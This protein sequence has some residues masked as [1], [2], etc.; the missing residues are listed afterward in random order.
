MDKILSVSISCYN[1]EEYLYE[2][3][4]PFTKLKNMECIEVLID[5]NAATDNSLAIAR[6]F[7]K[8][9]P[10]LFSC[11]HTEV[12]GSWGRPLNNNIK[13]AKGKYFK[14][15]D[16]DDYLDTEKLDMLIDYLKTVND[17]IVFSGFAIF[18]NQNK[19]LLYATYRVDKSFFCNSVNIEKVSDKF[20]L[21]MHSFTVRT[22]LLQDNNITISENRLYTDQ[23]YISKVIRYA[24]TVSALD[25]IVYMYRL[26][27]PGQSIT[28]DSYLKHIDEHEDVIYSILDTATLCESDIKTELLYKIA[29]EA[30]ITHH[31]LYL[32]NKPASVVK[33][34]LRKHN[35]RIRKYYPDYYK[36]RKLPRYINLLVHTDFNGI[37]EILTLIKI[38]DRFHSFYH[39][40][41]LVRRLP[42][43]KEYPP[44]LPENSSCH[45]SE[46]DA[47]SGQMYFGI[48]GSFPF[49]YTLQFIFFQ[50]INRPSCIACT[51]MDDVAVIHQSFFRTIF[52][53]IVHGSA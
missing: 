13:R 45:I 30:D 4:T 8:E 51:P 14:I 44:E 24:H 40:I 52:V 12:N 1:V 32:H 36:K 33:E 39:K 43:F 42:Y 11:V 35:S 18:F 28:T 9:Y 47:N 20:P 21:R 53:V 48:S 25:E 23:E 38:K 22:G 10:G 15:L 5:D 7:E 29:N 46:P 34:K 19:E 37:S 50:K 2:T 17:D 31:K 16:G 41:T 6:K 49:Q 27:R 3:L 26:G